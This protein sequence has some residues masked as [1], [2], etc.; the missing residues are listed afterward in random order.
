MESL[1]ERFDKEVFQPYLELLHTQYR[2]HSR[3][4]HAE[5]VWRDQLSAKEL[6][7]GPYLEKSQIYA[8]GEDISTLGLHNSVRATVQ[9]RLGGKRLYKHQTE[10]IKGILNGENMIVATGTSSGKTLCYQIPILNDLVTN[11]TPGLRAIIIYPL[12]ALVNDQLN[13]W[14]SML[15]DHKPIL[16]ARFTGQTPASHEDYLGRLEFPIRA[17]YSDSGL[18]QQEIQRR[19]TEDMR[20]IVEKEK[21]EIPN[22]LNDRESIRATPPHILITNFS[23]LEYLLER[24]VDAPIFEKANLK[25]LV[26]D[27]AHAYQ[28]IQSTEI[29]C[30]MRRLKDR[31]GIE[32]LTCIATSATL[33]DKTNPESVKKVSE[34][35]ANLFDEDFNSPPIYGT[36]ATPAQHPQTV[37]PTPEQYI[38]AFDKYEKT[39]STA[40]LHE[41]GMDKIGITDLAGIFSHDK[42]ILKLETDILTK[43]LR[44]ADAANKLWPSNP[45]AQYGLQALMG[46][47]SA[48]KSQSGI[49]HLPTRL[50]Y[51]VRAQDGFYVCL[52]KKCPGRSEDN[53]A[54][55]ITRNH[56]NTLAGNCPLCAKA[57]VASKLVEVV[58]CRK[59]G[60]LFAALQDL[61]PRR[62]QQ[63]E[64]D[65][66]AGGSVQP[67]FDSFSTE[68]GW[69]SD[70]FWSY[71]SIDDELPYPGQPELE[72]DDEDDSL[73]SNPAELDWCVSCGKKQDNGAGDNCKCDSP[74]IRK[75][76]IFHRQ[77]PH[78]GRPKDE[79]NLYKPIKTLLTTCPNCGTHN[80]SGLEPLRRFQESEDE[81]GLSM[82][83]PLSH[84][85]VN[86]STVG[87]TRKLLCFTDNRQKAAAFPSILEEETFTYD[88]GR[89]IT[90]ILKK[91]TKPLPLAELGDML[92][93][94]AEDKTSPLHDPDFFLPVSHLP[95]EEIDSKKKK[96]I[97]QAEIFSYF[98]IP[99]AAKESVE[100]FGIA[101]VEYALEDKALLTCAS[102]LSKH[103]VTKPES[104]NLIQTLLQ[105]M[106]RRKAFTLPKNVDPDEQAFGR[107]KGK[108]TYAEIRDGGKNVVGWIPRINKSGGFNNN[109][110][111]SFLGRALRI[112][113]AETLEATKGLWQIFTRE[114]LVGGPEQWQLD[115]ER[116][117]ALITKNRYKCNRCGFISAYSLRDCCPKKSCEG[118]LVKHDFI[119]NDE[120]IVA[121]WIYGDQNVSFKS[122]RS[123]EHTAQID[124]DLAKTIEEDFRANG[125]NLLSSTTTFEMGI[126]IGDLQKVLLRNAPPNSANYTQRIGRAGRG[127]DK[128][129]ICVTLCRRSKYDSDAWKNPSDRLMLGEVKSPTV[130]VNNSVV[131]Q[132][133]FNAVIFSQYLRDKLI[134][135]K[136]L[137][138]KDLK[139]SLPLELFLSH[140][141]KKAVP[142]Y[143]FKKYSIYL[144]FIEWVYQKPEAYFFKT[145]KTQ[146]WLNSITT[147]QECLKL[148]LAKY[149][150]ILSEITGELEVL[151]AERDRLYK[152]GQHLADVENALKAIISSDIIA[153]LAKKGFLPRYAFPL[154]V[155][156]LETG[157]TQ[158]TKA[159]EVELSRERGIA[160]SEFAPS[161]QVVAHK[162][163]FTSSGLYIL[164]K[165]DV[166]DVQWF[167]KCP[168]CQQIKTG[169]TRDSLR[170]NCPICTRQIGDQFIKQFVEPKAFSVQFNKDGGEI[171]RFR[172]GSLLRQRQGVT[173][174]I[175][176]VPDQDFTTSGNYKIA[177]N[178][179]GSL[180]RYNMGPKNEG[181]VL[182]PDC[183]HSWPQIDSKT[184]KPHKRL[185]AFGFQKHCEKVN[186][187]QRISYGHRFKSYCLIVRPEH[188]PQSVESLAFALQRG[189]YDFLSIQ[190]MDIG[191]SWRWLANKSNDPKPEIIF[192]DKAPGGAGFVKEAYGNWGK[193]LNL[194][195]DT[196]NQCSCEKACYDCLKDYYNQSYHEKL[197][198]KTA[199]LD[200]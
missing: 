141:T 111:T 13:E 85:K 169:L 90:G 81:T 159:S 82:A 39:S 38:S 89:I 193:V 19:V 195:K 150:E 20:A 117:S 64:T 133:H 137:G 180:F 65:L 77:C 40:A 73:L 72:K 8:P 41:L 166:P 198:R 45:Q 28:G 27:E 139:Q 164:G 105:Y 124:K 53:P 153:V 110:V 132:R 155:V 128:N 3:F 146:R 74:H 99:D 122:L 84:F 197:D 144:N 148:S 75:I 138:S 9:K 109:V 35:A 4:A 79:Q 1:T 70:S 71:F 87:T 179:N 46:L 134:T 34:F 162:K 119:P 174:F 136:V 25:F 115:H 96:G 129:A 93:T 23:M 188:K 107:V 126:N 92:F 80:T 147:Y 51:F 108:I 184:D 32:K 196:C 91:S 61:G 12:N 112:N 199:S 60:Y 86:P 165:N 200:L 44:L 116:M 97:W 163:V 68:L 173:H 161:S 121:K 31:L 29:A 94:I 158:W 104:Y 57:G 26:L 175:D 125:I 101:Q 135:E 145:G 143:W 78:S 151:A 47:V 157:L 127:L 50:H 103:G 43:P 59:C 152:L 160:I 15:K 52:H 7:N 54:F 6:L 76:K 10:A 33:G 183:G 16:F 22:R 69:A 120:N 167:S 18:S 48:A 102:L 37:T 177:L 58:F 83:I 131:A 67:H 142:E 191:V 24:P 189:I 66:P 182:C 114:L 55:F 30:L 5:A 106:R 21:A 190:S 88:L 100:D 154:D 17:K 192:Y 172:R 194:A 181:F 170:G 140:E 98:G 123:E 149:A 56:D 63:E 178:P 11:P 168:G 113:A 156:S 171:E 62:A 36:P 186:L 185:R 118:K 176:M 42:N 187:K 130:F 95:D 49:D 14:E 2:F